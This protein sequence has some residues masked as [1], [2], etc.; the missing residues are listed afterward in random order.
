ME[1]VIKSVQ[2]VGLSGMKKSKINE[3]KIM[4]MSLPVYIIAAF[5]ILYAAMTGILPENMV[6]AL[7]IM[8]VLGSALNLMG[9]K[10]PIIRS[11]LGG[12]AVFC[13]FA[14]S[15]LATFG[16]LPSAVVENC[17]DFMN[18]VG[19][20]DFYIA[21]LITG[22]ILGMNRD[23]LKKAAVRFLPISFLS[24]ACVIRRNRN[25][26]IRPE[27]LRSSINTR[28]YADHSSYHLNRSIMRRII[29]K[30]RRILSSR[31]SNHSWLMHKQ[32]GW[33]WKY[34]SIIRF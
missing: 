32:Y 11:Y 19:F 26:I 25:R 23:L 9:N 16:I 6:G 10:I 21:A 29:W 17:K 14:S 15:A 7:A 18:N 24:M 34:R 4:G 1:K 31:S 13:I 12:G 30:I 2:T 33:N 3:I 20:L 27:S 5:V 22:S 28:I 8:M